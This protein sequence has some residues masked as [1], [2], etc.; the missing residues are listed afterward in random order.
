MYVTIIKM[1][2]SDQILK[3]IYFSSMKELKKSFIDFMIN[4]FF[5]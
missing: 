4:K 5:V 2:H 3:I 1:H